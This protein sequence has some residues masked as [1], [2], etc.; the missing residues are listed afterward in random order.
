MKEESDYL[1]PKQI[2]TELDKYIVG[3]HDA[4]RNV[5]IACA[6]GGAA[7]TP[8]AKCSRTLCPTTSS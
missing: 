8:P 3:Q 6:T 1:T 5:A 7:C 2:V 4:K